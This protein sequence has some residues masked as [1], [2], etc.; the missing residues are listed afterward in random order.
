MGNAFVQRIAAP[1][2][3]RP[4]QEQD[5]SQ[6]LRQV[7]AAQGG[8]RPLPEA[9]RADMESAFGHNLSDV[10]V[11]DDPQ[12][13]QL[14]HQLGAH[15]FAAGNDVF[16]RAGAF[17]PSSS[18]GR[19]TLAHELTHVVQQSSMSAPP[20]AGVSSPTDASEVEA[21]QVARSV[22]TTRPAVTA[23]AGSAV[24]RDADSDEEAKKREA[25][26]QATATLDK[27][28][29]AGNLPGGTPPGGQGGGLGAALN[30]PPGGQ[31][32]GLGAALNNNIGSGP[33]GGQG[34]GLGAALNAPPGGQGGGLGAALNT[35]IGSGPAGGQGGG[36]GSAN[37]GGGTPQIEGPG[38]L[39]N[40]PAAGPGA[41][42]RSDIGSGGGPGAP[43]VAPPS[44]GG[45]GS[46][47]GPP[48]SGGG[49]AGGGGGGGA[50][51]TPAGGGGGAGG[52]GAPG[53][54]PGGGGG[55]GG[56]PGTGGGAPGSEPP[57]PSGPTRA[58]TP[59]A[60]APTG[61]DWSGLLEAFED[62]LNLTRTALEVLRP[63]PVYGILLGGI[64]DGINTYQ[65][66]DTISKTKE[67]VP[68]TKITVGLRDGIMI[69]N[70][71]AGGVKGT[72]EWLQDA[73]TGSVV[74]AEVDAITAPVIEFLSTRR[75]PPTAC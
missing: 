22:G 42:I 6:A 18:A 55:G 20:R 48:T 62:P 66:F 61:T 63:I 46:G 3:P 33:P 14:S 52:G 53:T 71:A 74:F 64:A 70:N 57:A 38:G 56:G 16:F 2:V 67:D 17:N 27:P 13:D 72:C 36:L 60:P 75:L 35:N 9:T 39:I 65:D 30:A 41:G 44:S 11:H 47:G 40:G 43:V 21:A 49:G 10:R 25:A 59:A 26:N 15:A 1:P 68:Y 8:G 69:L 4:G 58:I 7:E 5:D 31:G 19:E 34:G 12:A 29:E 51:T 73:A 54:T 50:P 32:G 28:P 45:G 24:N 37:L 23:P